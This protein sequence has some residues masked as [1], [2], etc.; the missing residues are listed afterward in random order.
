MKERDSLKTLAHKSRAPLETCCRVGI[1]TWIIEERA[2][3]GY[4]GSEGTGKGE[5][6]GKGEGYMAGVGVADAVSG[7]ALSGG[8]LAGE[9]LGEGT[10]VQW[11]FSCEGGRG[12]YAL[13]SR[14]KAAAEISRERTQQGLPTLTQAHL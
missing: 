4:S 13:W 1:R 3:N 10:R 2:G 6:G 11:S 5:T 14:I 12:I 7:G 8:A 9:S